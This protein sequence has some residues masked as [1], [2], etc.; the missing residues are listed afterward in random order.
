MPGSPNDDAVRLR[1]STPDKQF[2]AIN[3]TYHKLLNVC[4]PDDKSGRKE[5]EKKVRFRLSHL[6]D[7]IEKCTLL[8]HN[9]FAHAQMGSLDRYRNRK[10]HKLK[11]AIVR[12]YKGF[13]VYDIFRTMASSEYSFHSRYSS[14]TGE[15][16]KNRT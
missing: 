15:E 10:I 11:D 13:L 14:L 12:K 16:P 3:R 1:R 7:S 2:S 5:Y 4:V 6:S 8:T 9:R